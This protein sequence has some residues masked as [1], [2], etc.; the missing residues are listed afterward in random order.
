MGPPLLMS[1]CELGVSETNDIISDVCAAI[2]T[3]VDVM[4]NG[5]RYVFSVV[6]GMAIVTP[7]VY[8]N[9]DVRL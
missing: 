1:H 8:N 7:T 3:S 4:G 2:T 9:K 6:N 5:C